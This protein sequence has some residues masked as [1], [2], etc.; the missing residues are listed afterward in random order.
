[1]LRSEKTILFAYF[2]VL[3]FSGSIAL[4]TPTAWAGEEPLSYLDALFTSVSAVCVT[5][6]ITVDTAAYTR[7]GQAVILVLIQTGGLGILTFS[8][9]FLL[10]PGNRIS[11]RNR[12]LIKDYYME[13]IEYEPRKILRNI[14]LLTFGV[15]AVGALALYTQFSG[16]E[17]GL[18]V[19]VFHAV[20]AFCNAGF[21]T[22]STNLEGWSGNAAVLVPV[23]L[24]V[25]SGGLSF[26]V[27]HDL[28]ARVTGATGRLTLH[29][30]IVLGMTSI[31]IAGGFLFFFLAER[32]GIFEGKPSSFAVLNSLFL[33][34]TPRTAGFNT[35]PMDGLSLGSKAVNLVLMFV[36]AAPASI[37]GGVKV[38]TF[39]LIL[40]IIFRGV[41]E[42]GEIRLV[43][44]RLDARSLSHANMFMLKALFI[45]TAAVIG[46]TVTEGG[47]D[48]GRS[49]DFLAIVFEAVSAF[50]T[51]GLSLGLTPFLSDA[52]KVIIILTMFA[53]RV[54]LVSMAI[55]VPGRQ[56]ERLI[57]YPKG[58]VM[59]G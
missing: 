48:Q 54:G 28:Y 9:L 32:H 5:G 44:R 42:N 8:T 56:A 58:E 39:F 33:S 53:G 23:M 15:E 17:S 10:F 34:V 11:F 19:S 18:F 4:S 37:A 38:T 59:I 36:G 12:K 14:L 47:R 46:L 41:D 31:L 16:I 40:L 30:K 25:V 7:F 55:P 35:V 27:I 1:M 22:F 6:L 50:G 13:S 49:A 45:L 2:I 24:L 3:I 43:H 57:E 29:A 52:G 51:V 26:A 20:S 21:S